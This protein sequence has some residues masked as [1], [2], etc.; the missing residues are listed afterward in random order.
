MTTESTVPAG[1]PEVSTRPKRLSSWVRISRWPVITLFFS[2]ASVIQTWPLAKHLSDHLSVWSFFPYDAW[3]FLW[4]LWWVKYSL[5]NLQTNPFQSDYLYAPQG[6]HLYLHPLT[7]VSGVLSLPLQLITGNL[8]LSWNLLALIYLALSG[9]GG[10]LLTYRVTRNGLAGILGG[11]IFAFAP[12]TLMRLGGHWNVFATWPIP[13]FML[14][15]LR[16]I[17]SRGWKDAAGAGI[18][19]AIITYNWIEFTVDAGTVLVIFLVYWSA[20]HL[21]NRERERLVS[22]WRGTAILAVVWIVLS[23]PVLIPTLRDGNSGDY[24]Q[25]GSEP[26]VH[27]RFS[28]D[29]LAYVTPSPLW[30]PGKDPA[31]AGTNPD[32]QSFNGS[33]EGTAYLGILP[34]LLAGVAAVSI[35]RRTH[36]VVPWLIAF[37]AFAVLALGP[38]LWVDSENTFSILGVSF[39]VPLPYQLYEKLPFVSDRRAPVRMIVFASL[40]LSVLSGIGLTSLMDSV[41]RYW[42]IAVP[43]LAVPVLAV[44]AVALERWNAS[45]STGILVVL[46]LSILFGVFAGAT[47]LF[48][49]RLQ[50]PWMLIAPAVGIIALAVVA[51]EY[52]NPPIA[53]TPYSS[54]AILDNIRREPGDFMVLEVPLGRR[55]GWTCAGDCTGAALVDYY[56]TLYEKRSVGG[57][58]S[59][60]RSEGFDWFIQQ[61]G[62]RY[63]STTGF[64]Q[65]PTGD[66]NNREMV[67]QTFLTNRIKYVIVHKIDPGGGLISYVGQREIDI[68]DN[69]LR[70]IA[71]LESFYTDPQMNIY[72]MPEQS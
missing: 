71:G 32:L 30:G 1:A 44:A 63:L 56:Q 40:A 57:Y 72:R 24:Y 52:W 8:I 5:I 69:Y 31:S 15:V 6:S 68:M 65:G 28:A 54:P 18:F 23:A 4:N 55:T 38:H 33:I 39:S 61:P 36:Q 67:R 51:L 3:A 12:Y 29:L 53:V 16:L 46:G 35:R 47:V 27:Q 34:L 62:L 64:P 60:V 58:I 26:G 20:V 21:L 45:L 7:F 19:L 42:R 41:R 50:R 13:F 48:L 70:D 2:A 66:D 10:Y 14:F 59:R 49:R 11:Y 25:P 17:D 22:L 43:L 37:L 9:I